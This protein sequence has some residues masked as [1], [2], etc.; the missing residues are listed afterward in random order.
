MLKIEQCVCP[1][2]VDASDKIL[3]SAD[4]GGRHVNSHH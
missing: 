1:G 3:A 4:V 2:R